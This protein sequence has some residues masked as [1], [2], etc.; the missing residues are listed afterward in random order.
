MSTKTTLRFPNVYMLW[1]FAQTVQA[2]SIEINT[3][4]YT[5]TCN[6]TENEVAAAIKN[7]KAELLQ[8]KDSSQR[9]YSSHK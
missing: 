5:L 3:V 7:F 1:Q 6:C 4:N 9:I 2:T 8:E